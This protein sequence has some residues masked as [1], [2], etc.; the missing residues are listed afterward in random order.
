M[1]D[2]NDAV[3]ELNYLAEKH[4]ARR[5][6]RGVEL[7]RAGFSRWIATAYQ[8]SGRRHAAVSEFLRG[9]VAYRSGKS[10]MRAAVAMFKPPMPIRRR[11]L[12]SFRA[13]E[14]DWLRLYR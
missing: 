2:P 13:A 4:K 5:A 7:D 9:G 11:R 14:P 12:A 10:L 1:R 8:Q 6:R 3:E